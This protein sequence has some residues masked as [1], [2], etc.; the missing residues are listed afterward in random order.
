MKSIDRS[1]QPTGAQSIQRLIASVFLG[2]GGWCLVAPASVIDLTVRPE[3][4]SHDPIVLVSI[5]AFGAQ[6][7]LAGLLAALS[8]FTRA[9]FLGFGVAVLPFFVFDWWFYAVE[10]LFNEL[11][12]IDAIGNVILLVLCWRGYQL[13]EG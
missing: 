3:H 6:A 10:P 8:R 2:L 13:A 11:I 5:G 1:P 9:T 12:L 7:C 4:A